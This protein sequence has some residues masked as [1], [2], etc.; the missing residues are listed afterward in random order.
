ML[1]HYAFAKASTHAKFYSL[2]IVHAH[3]AN[4]L[5]LMESAGSLYDTTRS[6]LA[7]RLSLL[8]GSNA[9]F[10]FWKRNSHLLRAYAINLEYGFGNTGLVTILFLQ[11]FCKECFVTTYHMPS[12]LNITQDMA[13]SC[14]QIIKTSGI[15]AESITVSVSDSVKLRKCGINE[16]INLHIIILRKALFHRKFLSSFLLILTQ[17]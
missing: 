17:I 15:L 1:S 11:L 13:R 5:P 6:K 16:Q 8:D 7:G 10:F 2:S 9:Y 4:P 3:C 14:R 12:L